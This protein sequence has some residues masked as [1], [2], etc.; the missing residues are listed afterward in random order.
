[1][2]LPQF[3]L[4]RLLWAVT[5]LSFAGAFA[6]AALRHYNPDSPLAILTSSF[7]ATGSAAGCLFDRRVSRGVLVGAYAGLAALALTE[8]ARIF[9]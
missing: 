7:M 9:I 5:V 1:M 4:S 6:A 3:S 8:F 2:V